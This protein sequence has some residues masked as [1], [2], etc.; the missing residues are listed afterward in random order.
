M[1][2]LR[3]LLI[4]VMYAALEWDRC[5]KNDERRKIDKVPNELRCMLLGQVF[6]D[7]QTHRQVELSD[8]IEWF[9]EIHSA[10]TVFGDN[11]P[12]WIDVVSIQP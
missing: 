7:F 10:K 12:G 8:Y 11:K 5:G 1:P 2:E 4:D 9:G 3:P 6:R